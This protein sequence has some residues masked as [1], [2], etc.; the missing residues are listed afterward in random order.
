MTAAWILSVVLVPAAAVPRPGRTAGAV[1][2]MAM[3]MATPGEGGFAPC[4]MSGTPIGGPGGRCRCDA[5]WSGDNCS[6]LA[7]LPPAARGGAA[8][9]QTWGG[10]VQTTWGGSPVRD[11][12]SGTYHLFFSWI[13]RP[14]NGTSGPPPSIKEWYNC[15]VVA[16][17]T[18]TTPAGPY[19]FKDV[20]LEPRGG[21]FYDGT[22]THG[23]TVLALADGTFALYFMGLNCG[24]HPGLDCVKYQWIGAAH[25]TSLDGPWERPATP[26]LTGRPAPSWEGG[27]VANPGVIQQPDG[28]LLMVYRGL[29]DTGV[30]MAGAPSWG[31]PFSR[32]NGGAAVLG[33]ASP[34]AFKRQEDMYMWRTSRG[35]EMIFHQEQTD[36]R[37]GGHA[38]SLDDGRSWRVAGTAYT[39]AMPN[40]AGNAT[41]FARRERPQLLFDGGK[42]TYLFNGVVDADGTTHTVAVPLMVE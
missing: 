34:W 28:S 32:L 42:P 9:V 17:A 5:L 37:V 8:L 13:R 3:A 39:L 40:P 30:G 19:V 1:A 18:S 38:Y 24:M 15:S 11:P 7:T 2:D 20:V 31:A 33:P 35:I 23:P 41:V 26:V 10:A 16:H 25:A 6:A 21:T 22:A 14:G 29:G 12:V 36:P 27:M 4:S